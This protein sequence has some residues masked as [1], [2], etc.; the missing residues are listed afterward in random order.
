MD[1]GRVVVGPGAVVVG[2]GGVEG[3]GDGP[4]RETIG[5]AGGRG[6]STV[7]LAASLDGTDEP[8]VAVG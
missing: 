3:D 4:G 6:A 5:A 7:G 2:L 8:E 1:A